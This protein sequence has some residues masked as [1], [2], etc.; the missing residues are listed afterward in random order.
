VYL[1]WTPILFSGQGALVLSES[2]SYFLIALAERAAAILVWVGIVSYEYLEKHLFVFFMFVFVS[3]VLSS[4]SF[5]LFWQLSGVGLWLGA[6][7]VLPS[8]ISKVGIIVIKV[9]KTKL[10]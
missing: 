3:G 7:L 2:F 6:Y 4:F 1:P 9:T 10:R 5:V 8:A